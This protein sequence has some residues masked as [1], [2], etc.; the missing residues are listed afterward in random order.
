MSKTY[1][2]RS[3]KSNQ[4]FQ[5]LGRAE[6]MVQVPL[7]MAE[8]WEELQAEVEQLTGQAGLQI[9]RAMLEEEVRRRVGPAHRP[10]A[11]SPAV[12]W[13]R[14]GGYVIFGGQKVAIEHPR[15][16]RRE[17]QEVPLETYQR[18]QQDG[19]RQR[20]VREGILAGLSTR[21]THAGVGTAYSYSA[22]C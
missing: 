6:V 2:G 15:V 14:Q 7:P 13:G 12:R 17:G 22:S 8:V 18:L 10:D 21:K 9:I 16:R 19:R 1:Q 20:R 11:T 4:K 3:S 5:V